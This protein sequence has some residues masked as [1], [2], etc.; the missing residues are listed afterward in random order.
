MTVKRFRGLAP[1][2][3][4]GTSTPRTGK[5][6]FHTWEIKAKPEVDIAIVL[7]LR[8]N[9]IAAPKHPHKTMI[10][11]FPK[12]SCVASPFKRVKIAAARRK[13][14]LHSTTRWADRLR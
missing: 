13:F 14:L 2:S 11:E 9:I 1:P 4:L 3:S 5:V 7:D 8:L 12:R 6:E 10:V